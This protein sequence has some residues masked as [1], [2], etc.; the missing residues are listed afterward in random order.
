MKIEEMAGFFDKRVQTYEEHMLCHVDGA[1]EFYAKT[2]EYLPRLPDLKLLDLGC[3][4]G[5]ELDE[6]FKALPDARVTGIDLS[7]KMLQKL[8]EK[9]ADKDLTLWQGSYFEREL[10]YEEFDAAVSVQSLH[11]FT[12]EE[13]LPLYRK[14][15]LCLKPGGVYVETDYM[16]PTLQEQEEH[17]AVLSQ[18]RREQAPGFYHYD[19]PCTPAAQ[20]KFLYKAGFAVVEKLWQQGNTAILRAYKEEQA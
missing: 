8:K 11:H 17:M 2:A 9:H 13:K 4:T 5:L 12:P 10:G 19:A 15:Y 20:A 14:I 16:A 18:I 1:P 7:E 3:G 6:I